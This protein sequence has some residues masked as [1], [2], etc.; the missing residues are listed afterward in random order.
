MARRQ[1]LTYRQ[2]NTKK[3]A[4]QREASVAHVGDEGLFL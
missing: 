2:E 1:E 4:T 3:E